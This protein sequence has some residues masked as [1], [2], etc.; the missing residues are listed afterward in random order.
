MVK[1]LVLPPVR[2]RAD[3]LAPAAERRLDAL[4]T[5]ERNALERDFTRE[6]VLARI[7]DV[8][9]LLTSWGAPQLDATLLAAAPRLRLVGHAAGSVKGFVHPE[10]FARGIAV[11]HAAWPM[12]EAVGEWALAATLAALR[13][14]VE[15]DRS[16]R[17][18]P[19]PPD[20]AGA[21]PRGWGAE[22][23]QIG[24]GRAL[25]GKRVGVIAASMTGRVFIELLKPFGCEVVVYD[26]YL[27]PERATALGVQRA[28]TLDALMSTCEVVANHAPL[29][30]E[31][32]GM[33]SA[34]QLARLPD[35]ALFV[36][37]ANA[38]TVD[39]EALTRELAGGRIH[40]ALDVYP[41]EPL[42][43]DSALRTLPNVVLNPHVA[44]ATVE[45]RFNLGATIVAEFER[46]FAGQ[47]LRFGII[48]EQFAIM[49]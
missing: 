31:T 49:A 42:P 32:R 7:G 44:G 15:F 13:R 27:S 26:P 24:W 25:Y 35:G 18:P 46:F 28:A 47:P 19:P 34:A 37:T 21:R 40:A 39:F 14:V 6:E 5:V 2:L 48:R 22:K 41:R 11:T 29:T 38:H 10:V 43:Q 30:E 36:S 33:V 1:L 9:A 12:A 3:L 4:G 20:E 16:M 23:R 17:L 8:D 45:S